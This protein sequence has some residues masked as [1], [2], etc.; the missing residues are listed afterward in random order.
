MASSSS[1]AFA[2]LFM[3]LA[4]SFMGLG[5]ATVYK[6][7]D[8]VGWT[9]GKIDYGTWV[10][11]KTF[12]VGD[13]LLF[14]YNNSYHNVAVVGSKSDF[15]GCQVKPVTTYTTRHTTPSSSN[16]R[17]HFY[18]WRLSPGHCLKSRSPP[19]RAN[20]P[21][22]LPL[23]LHLPNPLPHPQ[24]QLLLQPAAPAQAPRARRRLHLQLVPLLRLVRLRRR[25][26]T[27]LLWFVR[28][29]GWYCLLSFGLW[30]CR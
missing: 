25:I 12:H 7:G 26:R 3:V 8:A 18:L 5:S 9:V 11:K 27:M 6:V 24:P 15:D 23:P 2:C 10:S 14:S 30:L 29:W 4:F 22:L 28:G 13:T 21:P 16:P 19:S 1:L 20:P 17:D